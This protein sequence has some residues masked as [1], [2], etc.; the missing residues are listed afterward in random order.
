MKFSSK[1]A[2]DRYVECRQFAMEH[3]LSDNFNEIFSRLLA[4]ERYDEFGNRTTEVVIGMDYDDKCFS[5]AELDE[6]GNCHLNGGIIFHGVPGQY[7]ENG[8][9]QLSPSYGWQIHT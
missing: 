2:R 3:K 8:S 1:R 4:W 5:F 7:L 6:L 9:C